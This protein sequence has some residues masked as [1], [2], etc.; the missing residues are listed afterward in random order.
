M[1]LMLANA[2][3]QMGLT[4]ITTVYNN[5]SSG[6]ALLRVKKSEAE[7]TYALKVFDLN[8]NDPK[9]ITAE[10]TALNRLPFGVVPHVHQVIQIQNHL[11]LTCDW[12]DGITF[13][14]FYSGE[15]ADHKEA[16][17]RISL[18][19]KAGQRLQQIHKERLVHRDIKPE[20]LLIVRPGHTQIHNAEVFVIDFGNTVQKRGLEEGTQGYRAPEQYI[21]RK[22]RLTDKTDVFGLAQTLWFLLTGEPASLH[23]NASM[24][25][26]DMPDYPPLSQQI[27]KAAHLF[28]LLEMATAFNP[29]ERPTLGEFVNGLKV[30]TRA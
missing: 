14:E 27:K 10:I 8:A 16:E 2:L 1:E 15:V 18:V 11:F 9:N 24:N 28:E 20:N 23:V 29:S 6:R 22:V 26:W 21:S 13:A 3:K 30:M 4:K 17:A 25:D 7:L 19:V 5:K 12:I